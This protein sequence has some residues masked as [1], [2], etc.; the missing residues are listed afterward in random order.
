MTRWGER[1][2]N[3]ELQAQTA[4]NAYVAARQQYNDAVTQQNTANT[5]H[6][7]AQQIA[8]EVQQQAHARVATV[9]SQCLASVFENPYTLHIEFVRKRGQTEA[10]LWFVRG[11]HYMEPQDEAA[12]GA[13]DLAA[14]ALRLSCL[15]LVK[16]PLARV[17]V[18]DE[19]FRNPSPRYRQSVRALVAEL[20]KKMGVQ[21]VI[22]TNIMELVQ[23][24]TIDLNTEVCDGPTGKND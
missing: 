18:L 1:I 20:S 16:P 19:P 11:G 10:V 8:Q 5:A 22:V 15:A 23:G 13:V 4:I 24:K 17:L 9:A 7:I 12:G 14:L 21:F 6:D 3:L 2:A